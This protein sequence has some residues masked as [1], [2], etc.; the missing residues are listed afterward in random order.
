M[1]SPNGA[2]GRAAN[3]RFAKGNRGGPGN[4]LGKQVAAL[5]SAMLQ[6]V[7][8]D[9]LRQVVLALLKAAKEGNIAAAKEVLDRCLGR[10]IEADLLERLE[11]L[12]S[13]T[14]TERFR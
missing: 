4:P 8:P 9:D 11:A 7:T 14:N 12:E 1:P 13:I 3:G 6:A 10:P 2:D 5:R